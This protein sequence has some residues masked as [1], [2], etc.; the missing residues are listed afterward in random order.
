MRKNQIYHS[1]LQVI[2]EGKEPS[3]EELSRYTG[4][5]VQ[6]VHRCL[7]ALEKEGRLSTYSKDIFGRKIRM[8]SI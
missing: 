4:F 3:V 5:P 1:S 7:N 2:K 8:V 6:D